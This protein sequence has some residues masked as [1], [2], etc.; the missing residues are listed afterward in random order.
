MLRNPKAFLFP[1][2]VP[3]DKER[4]VSVVGDIFAAVELMKVFNNVK[5]HWV[6]NLQI[7]SVVF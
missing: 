1:S 6:Y 3:L 5:S 2:T 7:S 4:T